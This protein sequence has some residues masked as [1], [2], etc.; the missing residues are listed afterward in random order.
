ME[1]ALEQH[2]PLLT[3][4]LIMRITC[5]WGDTVTLLPLLQGNNAFLNTDTQIMTQLRRLHFVEVFKSLLYQYLRQ[6]HYLSIKSLEK[7]DELKL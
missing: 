6:D 5:A 7:M 2:I 4:L 3:I 1:G